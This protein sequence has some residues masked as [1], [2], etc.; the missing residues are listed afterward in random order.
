M[1]GSQQPKQ[2]CAERRKIAAELLDL[3]VVDLE[4]TVDRIDNA[5]RR[6]GPAKLCRRRALWC[7]HH[8]AQAAKVQSVS[9]LLL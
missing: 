9:R 6:N 7:A 2:V 1:L 3:P 8:R 4:E 5:L